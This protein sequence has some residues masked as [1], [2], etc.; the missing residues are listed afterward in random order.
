MTTA[1]SEVGRASQGDHTKVGSALGAAF[2]DDPVFQWL[3]PV[4]AANR[5][6]RL[7]TFFS[8]M[9]RSY[10]RR[11][12]YVYCAGEGDGAAMWSAPGSWALPMSEVMRES[13]PAARAFGRNLTRALRSQLFIEGKHPKEPVHWYLGYVGVAPTQ[14]GRGLGAAML[15][16]VLDKADEAGTPAYLESS[17][18]RNLSLYERQGFKVVEDVKLLGTGPTVWRMWREPA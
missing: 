12:K 16:A 7:V 5:D 6:K 9:A 11:D 8:S 1:Q 13:V 3:I 10:L 18:E 2:I 4:D 15:R 14:Q 17:N